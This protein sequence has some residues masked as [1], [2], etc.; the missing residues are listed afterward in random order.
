MLKT[1]TAKDQHHQISRFMMLDAIFRNISVISWRR[2]PGYPEKTTDR[3]MPLST[4]FQLYHG[5]K[6]YW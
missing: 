4:I 5:G 6:F 3:L 2:K 1:T